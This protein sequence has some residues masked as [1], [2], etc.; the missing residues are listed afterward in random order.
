MGYVEGLLE[1][2]NSDCCDYGMCR[3]IIAEVGGCTQI[4]EDKYGL[5]TTPLHEAIEC[6][7]YD[8]ALELINEPGTNLDVDPDGGGTLIWELQYLYAET[9]EERKLES[10]YKFYDADKISKYRGEPIL[11]A[12]FVLS[13]TAIFFTVLGNTFFRYA[14]L[15]GL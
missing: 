2:L 5:K 12:S 6:G 14:L 4:I 13:K 8:F 7:H 10:E 3:Q 9:Q 1:L 11:P 15:N